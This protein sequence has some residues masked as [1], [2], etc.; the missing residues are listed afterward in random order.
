MIVNNTPVKISPIGGE[1][2]GASMRTISITLTQPTYISTLHQPL[3]Y[4]L[5]G[6]DADW[7]EATSSTPTITYTNL[8]IGEYT[9][10]VSHSVSPSGKPTEGAWGTSISIIHIK[11][12]PPWWRTWWMMMIY[13]AVL[14]FVFVFVIVRFADYNA[15][16]T[17]QQMDEEHQQEILKITNIAMNHLNDSEFN[18]DRFARE[19]AMSRSVLYQHL[20]KI[21][22]QTPN[23]FIL[24]LRMR[25]ACNLLRE[26]PTMSILEISERVGFNSDSY[27]I[28]CFHR[29]YGKSP[30]Q[31]RR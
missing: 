11:V 25:E 31:W 1:I 20:K 29:F 15:R 22:G 13:L 19:M 26:Y 18:V 27:F 14:V 6:F 4:R 8:P 10:Q 23:D 3:R 5:Q 28:K 16:K 9:L 21:V 30:A 24:S 17:R 12:L 7:I 2:E